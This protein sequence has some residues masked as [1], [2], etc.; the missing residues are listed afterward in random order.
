MDALVELPSGAR[1]AGLAFFGWALPALG[2][3]LLLLRRWLW[4]SCHVCRAYLTG[5][6]RRDFTNLGKWY[7]HLLR[8]SPTG[9]VHVHVFGCTITAN[10][11][12]VE[13]MLKTRFDNFPKGKPFTALL[14]IF[15]V[16]GDMWRHQRKVASLELGSVSVQSYAFKIVAQEVE[17]RLMPVLSD[18]ADRGT[19]LDL[20]DEFRRFC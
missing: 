19:V 16:D 1:C 20:Q 11:A 2:A 15:N 7:A 5:S 14:G 8:R 4:C 6:W 3:V 12:N 10:P 17:T 9:T 13:Y 18:G